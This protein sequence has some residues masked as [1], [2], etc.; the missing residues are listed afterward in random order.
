[1]TD[2]YKVPRKDQEDWDSFTKKIDK[3]RIKKSEDFFGEKNINKIN[4]SKMPFLEEGCEKL[5]KKMV[6]KKIFATNN[7]A[8]VQK[9]KY[10][11]ICLGTPIKSSL[12]PNLKNF[13]SYLWILV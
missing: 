10:I 5:I 3:V 13:I 8:E 12:N 2:K 1:M 7:L 6:K 11:I 4:N 9:C